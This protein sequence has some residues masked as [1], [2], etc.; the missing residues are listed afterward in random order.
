M[1]GAEGGGRGGELGCCGVVG[2]ADGGVG[3]GGRGGFEVIVVAE[4]GA[5]WAAVEEGGGLAG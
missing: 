5:I 4:G 1:C 3:G 2:G